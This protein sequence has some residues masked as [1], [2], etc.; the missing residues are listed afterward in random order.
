MQPKRIGRGSQRHTI[1]QPRRQPLGPDFH[2]WLIDILRSLPPRG[3]LAPARKR[4]SV[5]T[6]SI[7]L[8][9]YFGGERP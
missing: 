6:Y 2:N 3:R 7:E 8:M 4:P 1:P 9:L 5:V